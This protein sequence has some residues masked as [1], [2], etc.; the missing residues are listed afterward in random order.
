MLPSLGSLPGCFLLELGLSTFLLLQLIGYG[1]VALA[2]HLRAPLTVTNCALASHPQSP[3]QDLHL[4][5]QLL[6][7]VVMALEGNED[8][9]PL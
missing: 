5:L 2:P 4:Q 6:L 9:K 8:Q 7:V 3:W 1:R